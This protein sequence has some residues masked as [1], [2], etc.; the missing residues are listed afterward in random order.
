LQ[1]RASHLEGAA[2]QTVEAKRKRAEK[3]EREL[4]NAQRQLQERAG[5]ME[6][7]AAQAIEAEK[8][9]A[10][11]AE[12]SCREMQVSLLQQKKV[13]EQ[14]QQQLALRDK[15]NDINY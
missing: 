13:A 3:A 5:Q 6:G 15:M 11:R 10:E 1:E 4:V 9:R 7:A 8:K 2:A 14:Q 12:H